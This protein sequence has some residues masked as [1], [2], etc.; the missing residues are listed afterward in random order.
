[1]R[2]AGKRAT[3]V[4]IHMAGTNSVSQFA[5]RLSIGSVNRDSYEN[6]DSIKTV[7]FDNKK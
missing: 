4:L 2:K 3:Q 1:M 7:A 5:N 6:F